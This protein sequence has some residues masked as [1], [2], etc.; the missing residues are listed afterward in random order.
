METTMYDTLLQLPLFQGLCKED[1]TSIIERVKFHF[2]NFK[3]LETIVEQGTLCNQ[4]VFLLN[5]EVSLKVVDTVHGYIFTETLKAPH[6]IEPYSLFGMN[7]SYAASYQANTDVQILTIDKA[8]VYTELNNYEIF[9]LNYLNILSN[10]I[11]IAHQKLWNNHIGTL[12]EKFNNFLLAR[13]LMPQG[14]KTLQITME[15]LAKL[16]NETRINVSRML[17]ELQK[18]GLVQLRR[19]AI[20]IPDMEKL[21]ESLI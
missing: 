8:Y 14:E 15:D 7:T 9:R 11:Q 21:S 19:K 18:Q 6:I 1:F 5:G 4:L 12:N 17:N 20:Y 10:R 16:I 13:C 2:Q 3:R